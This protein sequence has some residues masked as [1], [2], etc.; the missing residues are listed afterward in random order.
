MRIL[1]FGTSPFAVPTLQA[2]LLSH[3]DVIGIV[4]QPD[5]PHGRGL[6]LAQSPVKKAAEALAP[7]IPLLQPERARAK[8]FVEAV[9]ELSPDALVVAA[10]GQILPQRLLDIPRFGGINV[11]G[12]LLPRWRGA[13]PIQYALMAGDLETGVTTMQMDAGLDTG[14]ILLE[15]R[16]AIA[17]EDSAQPLEE[18]LAALGA[19][20]LLET[21][22]RL[23]LGDCPRQPQ[24]S[25]Q[26]TYAPSLPPDIGLLDWAKPADEL[27][28]LIRG[29]TPRPGA[30]AFYNGRRIKVWKASVG[31]DQAGESPGV[32]VN[33][34]P[35]GIMVQAGNRTT[36]LL[37]EVQPESKTRMKASDWARGAHI[38]S[39]SRFDER[40]EGASKP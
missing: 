13:A 8:D 19:D 3:H 14:D 31:T 23:E 18:K 35:T 30:F 26:A 10:F 33:Q 24:D 7:A 21:L 37:D 11:H 16:I 12:S 4:T 20:L 29:L 32:V 28:H 34:T 40:G 6:Q 27:S 38:V 22:T 36:L 1:F 15:G 5:R 9:R 2:L 25:E 39:G 17:E